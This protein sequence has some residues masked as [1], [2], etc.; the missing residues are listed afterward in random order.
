M[1]R[2]GILIVCLKYFEF[3]ATIFELKRLYE[4]IILIQS[5]HLT[6]TYHIMFIVMP[7]RLPASQL[8][9]S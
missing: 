7:S 1:F 3:G 5:L 8:K 4:C 2:S 6:L 9:Q